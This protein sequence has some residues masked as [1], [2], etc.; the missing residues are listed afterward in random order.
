MRALPLPAG[1][2]GPSVLCNAP[3]LLPPA[4]LGRPAPVVR[5][6]RYVLYGEHLYAHGLEGA[7][8]HVPTR[9][10]TLDLDVHTPHALVH[11]LVGD[12]LGR[13]LGSER[14][15]LAA[16]FETQGSRRFPGDDIA[17]LVADGD[18]G[19]VEGALYV[20]HAGR[21]V[22]AYPAT[23]PARPTR[24]LP[25]LPLPTHLP[26]LPPAYRGLGSLALAGIRLG[27]LPAHGQAPAVPDPAVGSCVYSRLM[28]WLTSRLRSP[29]TS[30][31]WSM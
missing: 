1:L 24:A 30:T 19:V 16:P 27:T 11:G 14:R 3:Y 12:A 9:A 7:G 29:S 10:V 21:Y 15:A 17:L 8:G 2:S 6:A 25:L 18:D 22:P 4:P 13:H 20:D 26:L 28:F 5:L 23:G 31:F